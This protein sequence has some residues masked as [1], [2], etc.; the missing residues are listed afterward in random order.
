MS[1]IGVYYN[2]SNDASF[3]DTIT[4]YYQMKMKIVAYD[5]DINYSVVFKIGSR[6]VKVSSP[7]YIN[8]S[9]STTTSDLYGVYPINLSKYHGWVDYFCVRIYNPPIYK[10]DL[11]NI[12]GI[13]DDNE[14]CVKVLPFDF[15]TA[16]EVYANGNC[17]TC[18]NVATSNTLP[19]SDCTDVEQD[20]AFG[21]DVSGCPAAT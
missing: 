18:H 11:N 3:D 10:F 4:R 8:V 12:P 1:I 5:K 20:R 15:S 17:I 19:V 2:A 16:Q 21:F 7:A 14:M 9:T 6:A 13:S